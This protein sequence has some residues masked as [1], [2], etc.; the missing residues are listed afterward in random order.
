MPAQAFGGSPGSMYSSPAPT[1]RLAAPVSTRLLIA[2]IRFVHHVF[3]VS[4]SVRGHQTQ[5]S[6]DADYHFFPAGLWAASGRSTC[7]KRPIDGIRP[8]WSGKRQ[9]C[10]H[11]DRADRTGRGE[12]HRWRGAP[13]APTRN[14]APAGMADVECA[15]MR[16]VFRHVRRAASA[17]LAG[18]LR[19]LEVMGSR[20][21]PVRNAVIFSE[22]R[23]LRADLEYRDRV[24]V[25]ARRK[26]RLVGPPA[27]G[28]DQ[29]G[30]RPVKRGRHFECIRHDPAGI[31]SRAS[32][33]T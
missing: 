13:G 16:L 19:L 3:K 7:R 30:G 20:T 27:R 29:A 32:P 5:G 21:K 12:T 17:G 33:S 1:T 23:C 22:R 11:T 6:N 15:L 31:Q 25:L 9:A 8:R 14:G 18:A 26:E 24:V 28:F 2:A 10:G 4:R